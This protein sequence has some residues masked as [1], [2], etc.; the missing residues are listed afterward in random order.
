MNERLLPKA[1]VEMISPERIDRLLWIRE[2]R[3]IPD[4]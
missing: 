4:E 1:D 2:I 3:R